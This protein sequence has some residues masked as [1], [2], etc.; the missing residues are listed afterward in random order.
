[1]V[2]LEIRTLVPLT[3]HQLTLVKFARKMVT[4]RV[5]NTTPQTT[6]STTQRANNTEPQVEI[7]VVHAAAIGVEVE[8][9]DEVEAEEVVKGAGMETH[10][11]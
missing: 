6:A 8:A 2:Y 11:E 9:V 4:T 3:P 1:M 7:G 5:Q 10:M